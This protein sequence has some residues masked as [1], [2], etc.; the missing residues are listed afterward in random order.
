MDKLRR[1][2]CPAGIKT[3]GLGEGLKDVVQEDL[4]LALFVADDVFLIP[5]HEPGEFFPARQGRVLHKPRRHASSEFERRPA[6]PLHL[7]GAAPWPE[8]ISRTRQGQT[9][10]G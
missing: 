5:P 3:T 2:G 6:E 8:L 1:L 9:L 4:R 7:H 10:L